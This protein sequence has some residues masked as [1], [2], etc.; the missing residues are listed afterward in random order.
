[1]NEMLLIITPNSGW[2]REIEVFDLAGAREA[3]TFE[4]F[5]AVNEYYDKIGRRDSVNITLAPISVSQIEDW[6]GNNVEPTW[7]ENLRGRYRVNV[8]RLVKNE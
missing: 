8:T 3:D 5:R 7:W 6:L 4:A 2:R 1:M